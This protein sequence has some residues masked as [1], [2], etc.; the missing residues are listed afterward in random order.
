MLY[1][2]LF[3]LSFPSFNF[4]IPLVSPISV[5]SIC[6]LHPIKLCLHLKIPFHFKGSLLRY[7]LIFSENKI[8]GNWNY[9]ILRSFCSVTV[10]ALRTS[11]VSAN[12][13]IWKL[14]RFRRF[15]TIFLSKCL[16]L[17]PDFFIFTLL[18]H[19]VQGEIS[20]DHNPVLILSG[21]IGTIVMQTPA[22]IPGGQYFPRSWACCL[23]QLYCGFSCRC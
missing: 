23:V 7:Q 9:M 15:C 12:C 19:P 16:L 17:S 1:C 13:C 10:G 21:T 5:M 3:F 11:G 18:A 2:L 6:S 14:K 4:Y 22:N 8:Q 20:S